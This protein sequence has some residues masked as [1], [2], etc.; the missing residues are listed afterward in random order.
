MS[1][2]LFFILQGLSYIALALVALRDQ[3]KQERKSDD[4]ASN[5]SE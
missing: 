2:K 3:K 1:L 5:L 4:K